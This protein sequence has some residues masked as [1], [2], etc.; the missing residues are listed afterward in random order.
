MLLT[1]QELARL[2][3]LSRELRSSMVACRIQANVSKNNLT[4]DHTDPLT[5]NRSR[6][7]HDAAGRGRR[8]FT[9]F[10]MPSAWRLRCCA[11]RAGMSY[12]AHADAAVLQIGT[13][14]LRS[15][16]SCT[17]FINDPASYVGGTLN[18]YRQLAIPFKARPA[19]RWCTRPPPCT[20]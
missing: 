3:M 20:R 15:D 12:G 1:P 14:R 2:N 13:G 8:E 19:R 5:P 16:L 17:V 9:D 6:I 18:R 11:V 4:A 10:A 7:V